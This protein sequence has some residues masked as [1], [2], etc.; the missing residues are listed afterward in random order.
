MT[1]RESYLAGQNK[2]GLVK[3]ESKITR[4]DL[5]LWTNY[6]KPLFPRNSFMNV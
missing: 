5:K 4:M 6:Y 1:P 3:I 2:Q